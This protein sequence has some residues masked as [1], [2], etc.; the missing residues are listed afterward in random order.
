M[1]EDVYYISIDT[2]DEK[3]TGMTATFTFNA[4]M[5]IAANNDTVIKF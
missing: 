2:S 3:L 1:Q 4:M 5:G